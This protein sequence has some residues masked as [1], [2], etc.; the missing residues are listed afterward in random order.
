VPAPTDAE[1]KAAYDA[2]RDQIGNA[3]LESVR[4]ELINY[5]RNERTQ[6]LYAALI[7]V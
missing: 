5:I 6:E 2:N 4:A 3:N 1:I 7:S